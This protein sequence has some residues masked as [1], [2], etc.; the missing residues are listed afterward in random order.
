MTADQQTAFNL[1]NTSRT[2]RGIPALGVDVQAQNKA[3]SWA[4]HLAAIGYL[5]HSN[6]TNGISGAWFAI[7]GNVGYSGDGSV[8]TTHAVFM[9]SPPHRANILDRKYNRL[10][11]GVARA[12][13]RVYVVQVFIKR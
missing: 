6:L 10:G 12:G 8:N 2:T 9:G 13:G 1:V 3:Q 5:A 7:A 11:T 4:Q